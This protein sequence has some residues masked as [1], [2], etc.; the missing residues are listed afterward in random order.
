[1]TPYSLPLSLSALVGAKIAAYIER[2]TP[3]TLDADQWAVVRSPVCELA[4][5]TDPCSPTDAKVVLSAL[6]RLLS[7]AHPLVGS[8]NLDAVLTRPLIDRFVDELKGE[9]TPSGRGNYL[10][11]LQRCLRVRAGEP[12]RT[13]RTSRGE[14]PPPYD[15]TELAQ[16]T[17]AARSSPGL[18][19]VLRLGLELGQIAPRGSARAHPQTLTD[20]DWLQARTAAAAVGV[21]LSADRL[22]VTWTIRILTEA[23]VIGVIV[24]REGLSRRDLERAVPNL[25]LPCPEQYR[26]TLRG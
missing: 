25:A 1:M 16:L 18:H 2:Y 11:R 15:T 3:T 19:T 12:A 9:V 23:T 6:C 22:R 10:G 20:A 4:A 26:S 7:W 14:E 8:F 5:G 21:P 13:K 24:A 17:M